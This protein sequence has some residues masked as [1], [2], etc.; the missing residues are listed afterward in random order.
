MVDACGTFVN[1]WMCFKFLLMDFLV[2]C[3]KYFFMKLALFVNYK[4]KFFFLQVLLRSDLST[5][6]NNENL[7]WIIQIFFDLYSAAFIVDG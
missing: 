7:N 5:E 1:G 3:S 6:V 4:N 2:F